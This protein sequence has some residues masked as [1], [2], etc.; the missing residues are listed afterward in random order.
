MAYSLVI[1]LS[2]RQLSLLKDG[3]LIR[4]YPVAVGKKQTPTPTG[5]FTIVN[6]ARQPGGAYGAFW[7]GLSRPHYGIHGTN[8]PSSIGK[9]ISNGC[10]RMYNNDIKELAA[11]VPVGTTVRISP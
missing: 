4:N 3:S 9:A 6:K 11:L 8:N 2:K 1:S 10:I 5:T 7:L